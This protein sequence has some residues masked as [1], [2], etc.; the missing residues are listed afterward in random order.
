[1]P[2]QLLLLALAPTPATAAEVQFEGF[3]RARARAFDTLSLDR[4][5]ATSEGLSAGASHRL[6]LRP[7]F[8]LTDKVGLFTELRGLD[9]VT[10]G[11]EVS[12]V[13][14]FDGVPATGVEYGLNAPTGSALLDITL[15][16][17]WGEV[18]TEYGR[19]TFG[20]VPLHW[21]LGLWLNDGLS[22]DVPFADHGDTTDRVMWEHLVDDQFF[23]RV[24]ADVPTERFLGREDDTTAF[25]GAVAYRSEDLTAGLLAQVDRTGARQQN[26]GALNVFTV[27]GAV[28]V[29]LGNLHGAAEVVAHF[30]AGDLDGGVNDATITAV[31]TAAHADLELD[32]FTIGLRAGI[33]TGDGQPNDA[34]IRAFTYDRDYS[35]GMFLFE[36][37]LPTLA[38]AVAA[39]NETNGGRDFSEVRSGT[40]LSNALWIKPT[41]RRTLLEGL[42]VRVSWLGA[43][44]AKTQAIGGVRT[45]RSYGN[46]FQVGASFL[47]IEHL[48]LDGQLGLFL[49]GSVYAVSQTED[50]SQTGFDDAAFG[51]QLSSRI[52][53]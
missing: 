51:F 46:E 45:S 20:R 13:E 12:G 30:G 19:F 27:D 7:R 34:G 52:V 41:V 6:W 16:R 5:A 9:G 18:H 49:P 29:T 31:G 15:S 10:W 43:R 4:G 24:A 47:G 26:T 21:G 2:L 17:V 11:D 42:E 32:I 3:Y 22:V 44:T 8:M 35:V 23:V 39:A 1:L 25:S 37:P 14:T 48:E 28:D 33:A 38:T 50:L 36:Q 53:F 40:A